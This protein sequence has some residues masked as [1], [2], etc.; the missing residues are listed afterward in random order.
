MFTELVSKVN[1]SKR[2]GKPFN[3]GQARL[4]SGNIQWIFRTKLTM[5]LGPVDNF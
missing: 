3:S 5:K 1:N 2:L 4:L